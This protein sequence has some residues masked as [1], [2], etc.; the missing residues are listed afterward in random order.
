MPFIILRFWRSE[1]RDPPLGWASQVQLSLFWVVTP[2]PSATPP[3]HQTHP[4]FLSLSQ[5]VL[6]LTRT[7]LLASDQPG[8]KKGELLQGLSKHAGSRGNNWQKQG[9]F[10][11]EIDDEE[12]R[13]DW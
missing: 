4:P 6:W 8:R 3:Y 10:R 13:E 7:V 12:L 5:G 11:W 2:Q 9:D 1:K